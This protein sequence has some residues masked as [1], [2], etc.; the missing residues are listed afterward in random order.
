[1]NTM[2]RKTA[3]AG[4]VG[5]ALLASTVPLLGQAAPAP[6]D[7]APVQKHHSKLKGALVGA[8]AGHMLGH[9]AKSGAVAGALWQHHKNKKATVTK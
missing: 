7:A 6:R 9:H 4:A 3:M 1:M 5:L 2:I 8:A